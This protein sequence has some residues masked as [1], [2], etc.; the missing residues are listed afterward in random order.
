ML[1]DRC[2]E[3]RPF[4]KLTRSALRYARA[5]RP[6]TRE[7]TML[8]VREFPLLAAALLACARP[9]AAAT[10]TFT[11]DVVPIL[12]KN[13]QECHRPGEIGPFSMLTYEQTRPWAKAIKAAV[14]EKKMPPWFAD[15]RYGKFSNDPSLTRKEIDTLVEWVDGGAPKGDS[16]ALP[17][18][19]S[20]VEGWGIPRPDVVFQLPE[21]YSIPATG[22]IDYLHWLIPSG[23]T[24]DKWV[25]FA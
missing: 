22:T 5:R 7:G 18:P 24:T 10:P 17:A 11:R 8:R 19:A 4:A 13:C 6:N 21:P 15:P 25:Q 9:G 20:F 23:F 2:A 16:A 1:L 3:R 14:L 12:Q